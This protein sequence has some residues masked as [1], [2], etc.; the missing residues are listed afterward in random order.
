MPD[1]E[2]IFNT[3]ISQTSYRK[4][5]K[6]VNR[7]IDTTLHPIGDNH[8]ETDAIKTKIDDLIQVIHTVFF[9]TL[10]ENHA[11]KKRIVSALFLAPTQPI[12]TPLD[13]VWDYVYLGVL[14]TIK[15]DYLTLYMDVLLNKFKDQLDFLVGRYKQNLPHH[16]SDVEGDDLVTIAQLELIETFKIW[17]PEKNTNP[18]PLAYSRINGAMKDHIR[19]ISKSDPTRFYDWIVDASHL[20]LAVNNDNSYESTIETHAEIDRMLQ[21]LTQRE[22]QVLIMYIKQDLTFKDISKKINVSESQI[23]RIYKKATEKIKKVL[24]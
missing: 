24:R 9:D 13:S 10:H 7:S 1:K 23:S 3:H 22:K 20:Y 15:V 4:K 5:S 17:I 8:P 11:L 16:V 18:W 21:L 19:Y 6:K 12:P 14:N 2:T